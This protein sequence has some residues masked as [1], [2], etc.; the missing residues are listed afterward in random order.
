M[1]IEALIQMRHQEGGVARDH[2]WKIVERFRADLVNQ[3][4]AILGNQAD[5]EDIAQESLARAYVDLAKLRDPHKLC[6]WLRSMNR[7]DALDLLRRRKIQREQRLATGEQATLTKESVLGRGG[8]PAQGTRRDE[9]ELVVR[10]VDGLPE[11]YR[12]IVVLRCWEKMTL[13]QIA[14]HLG[15]PAGTVRSRVAR[16]D[17]ILAR[18]LRALTSAQ[19]HPQ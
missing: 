18:K 3:A 16:A 19:E 5:A 7:C 2:F 10:A 12:E 14:I 9:A 8:T 4:F 11:Q 1:M 6:A 13:K 15:L 17:G